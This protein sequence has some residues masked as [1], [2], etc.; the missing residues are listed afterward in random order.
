MSVIY[1]LIIIGIL[2]S[3]SFLLA[4]FWAVQS[5]QYDDDFTPAVRILYDDQQPASGADTNIQSETIF[6]NANS[7][8][9][10]TED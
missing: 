3:G 5:G 2:F 10:E 7:T 4:F 6:K 8:D 1:I 9:T